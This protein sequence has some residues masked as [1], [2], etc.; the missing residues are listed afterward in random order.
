MSVQKQT[1]LRTCWLSWHLLKDFRM[2]ESESIREARKVMGI[3]FPSKYWD[4]CLPEYVG[5]KHAKAK[6]L[7][8]GYEEGL[9]MAAEILKTKCHA[10]H[11][12]TI[13]VES[14]YEK[15]LKLIEAHHKL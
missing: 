4:G 15:I 1:P 14:S 11:Q 5:M 8:E 12:H 13:C 2:K 9:R 10:I 6:G 7:I 3:K